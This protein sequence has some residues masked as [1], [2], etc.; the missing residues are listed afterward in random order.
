M[1]LKYS[2]QNGDGSL[3]IGI[4]VHYYNVQCTIYCTYP[5]SNVDQDPDNFAL[6]EL[7]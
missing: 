2:V 3:F 1:N 7:V 4:L 5:S 6:I